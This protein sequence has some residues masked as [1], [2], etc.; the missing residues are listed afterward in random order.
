MD[1][2]SKKRYLD[3]SDYAEVASPNDLLNK[4]ASVFDRYS[5]YYIQ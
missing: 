5:F 3:N 4:S 1:I 2:V